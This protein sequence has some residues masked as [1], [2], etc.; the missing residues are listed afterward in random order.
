MNSIVKIKGEFITIGKLLKLIGEIDTGGTSKIFLETNEIKINNK[1]P[2]GRSTK[3]FP[4]DIV[5]INDKLF[6]ITN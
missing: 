3:V 6:K 4:E 5:W 1:K 2:Q